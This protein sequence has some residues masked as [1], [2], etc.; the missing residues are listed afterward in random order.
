[1]GAFS[2]RGM[3]VE[4]DTG[5]R[6]LTQQNPEPCVV[7][8]YSSLGCVH[9]RAE[10]VEFAACRTEPFVHSRDCSLGGAQEC[11][12]CPGEAL[13]GLPEEGA[14]AVRVAEPDLL[15]CC[16]QEF[17]GFCELPS[18]ALG[19]TGRPDEIMIS[20]LPLG[21]CSAVRR[22]TRLIGGRSRCL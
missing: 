1:M 18:K 17:A 5:R 20:I 15:L 9:A 2:E 12:C 21:I 4:A 7:P 13:F 16:L 6:G 10:L 11:L 19:A 14:C 8:A 22:D 3:P